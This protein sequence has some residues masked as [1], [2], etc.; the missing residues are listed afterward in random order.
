MQFLQGNWIAGSWGR[1][2]RWLMMSPT[3]GFFF[4]AGE[5]ESVDKE[6]ES[7]PL[8][9]SFL[10]LL[11]FFLFVTLL[12][13]YCFL[14][15][16]ESFSSFLC[17][18]WLTGVGLYSPLSLFSP[19]CMEIDLYP[20]SLSMIKIFC[21]IQYK[22]LMGLLQ[23]LKRRYFVYDDLSFFR[24]SGQNWKRNGEYKT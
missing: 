5:E 16:K 14:L 9:E 23:I 10:F 19:F 4:F 24:I 7:C 8:V 2:R 1:W 20:E 13:D 12:W 15:A 21:G 6:S 11:F 18:S 22:I 3:F 17:L